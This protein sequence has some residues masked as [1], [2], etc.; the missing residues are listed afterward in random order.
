MRKIRE[1]FGMN[2]IPQ[3][4]MTDF[5]LGIINAVRDEVKTQAKACFFHLRLNIF[6]KIQTE[7]LQEEYNDPDDRS[8]K[9]ACQELCA[10]AF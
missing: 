4:V 3:I 10:L 5:E 7:G 8:I 2:R 9:I 1:V 6:R